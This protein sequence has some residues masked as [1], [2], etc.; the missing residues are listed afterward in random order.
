MVV[1]PLLDR[2]LRMF[3]EHKV[4]GADH[5]FDPACL[6][7]E[8]Q[9]S[10]R[11]GNWQVGVDLAPLQ[12]SDWVVYAKRPFSG[13]RAALASVALHPPRCDLQSPARRR[14]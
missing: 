14:R 3:L 1:V 5:R 10:A 2:P 6:V 7:L 11:R 4:M 13:P 9:V 8:H 12:K